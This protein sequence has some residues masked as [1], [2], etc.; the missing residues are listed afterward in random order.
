MTAAAQPNPSD[1]DE[2][3]AFRRAVSLF[4]TGIAVVT[5]PAPEGGGVHG[6]TINSFTS[7]SLDPP[8]IMISLK[9]GR[10]HAQ[11]SRE[12]R[13]GVSLLQGHQQFCSDHFSGRVQQ[14][15]VPDF[16][17][18]LRMPVLR[19]ALAW[20]DCEVVSSIE[21]CDHTVFFARVHACGAGEGEPLI[22]YRS[23]YHA[24]PRL[25]GTH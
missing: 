9:P 24:P 21:V 16:H 12:G 1:E 7:I 4:A 22:F 14:D 5:V 19:S 17:T 2:R 6:M 23:R 15:F 13:F 10:T 3:Q 11:V 8:T 20:F 18:P 25:V